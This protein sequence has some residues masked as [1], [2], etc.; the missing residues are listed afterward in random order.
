ML[1]RR[2]SQKSRKEV[3]ELNKAIGK[4]FKRSYKYLGAA[5]IIHDDW[6]NL[7][8]DILNISKLNKLKEDLKEELFDGLELKNTGSERHS[9]LL[10]L[11]QTE[12]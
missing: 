5:K 3:I 2:K 8:S 1:E 7:N 4:L 12:L 9:L 10:H 11:H 6:E